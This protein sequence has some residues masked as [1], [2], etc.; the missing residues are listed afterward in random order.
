MTCR[1]RGTGND[2]RLPLLI[3]LVCVVL[4]AACEPAEEAHR[5]E[6][7]KNVQQSSPSKPTQRQFARPASK[8][9]LVAGNLDFPVD[10]AWIEGTNRFFYTEKATGKIRTF[11]GGRLI[12]RACAVLPVNSEG[13]RGTLGIAADPAFVANHWLYVYYT[14]AEPLENRVTRFI[15]RGNLCTNPTTIVSLPASASTRHNGGQLEFVGDKLF[16][17][18]GDGYDSPERAQDISSPLGKILRFNRDGSIPEDNPFS[19][20]QRPN[21]VWSYGFRNPFGLTHAPRSGQLY[22]TD[23]GPD[24]DD[25]VNLVERGANYGMGGGKSLR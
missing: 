12:Q 3:A 25:E 24:C 1:L 4:T 23:N 21:P 10:M 18:V 20:P 14:N 22:A 11:A 6:G 8:P 7:G 13:E 2:P 15:V 5:D 19:R 16:V 9:R 17:S